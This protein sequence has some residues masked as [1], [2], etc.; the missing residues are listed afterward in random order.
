MFGFAWGFQW[1]HTHASYIL[2]LHY[3]HTY[4]SLECTNMCSAYVSSGQAQ[5]SHGNNVF[6]NTRSKTKLALVEIQL[7]MN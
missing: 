1:P 7:A 2:T 6:T 4:I 3:M 5:L